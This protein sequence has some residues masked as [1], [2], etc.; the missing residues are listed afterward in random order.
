MGLTHDIIDE[1]DSLLDELSGELGDILDSGSP[2]TVDDRRRLRTIWVQGKMSNDRLRSA[3]QRRQFTEDDL[4]S[5]ATPQQ[6]E[7]RRRTGAPAWT[8]TAEDPWAKAI[9]GTAVRDGH[10]KQLTPVGPVRVPTLISPEIVRL[11]VP[12][13]TLAGLCN[14]QPITTAEFVYL[15]QTGRDHHAAPVAVGTVKPTSFYPV[16]KVSDVVSTIAHVSDASPARTW[17]TSP[18]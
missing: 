8:K 18:P 17:P 15:R 12:A 10:F 13:P 11:G 2:L 7:E 16:E 4:D 1:N 3:L 6:V 9:I 14:R 5:L